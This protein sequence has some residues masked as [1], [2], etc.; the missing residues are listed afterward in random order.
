MNADPTI[1]IVVMIALAFAFVLS[2]R[3][4]LKQLRAERNER[5]VKAHKQMG[6][7]MRYLA[8]HGQLPDDV[9]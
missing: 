9:Q 3:K 2:L 1:A 7:G 5:Q 6:H 8:R 4:C